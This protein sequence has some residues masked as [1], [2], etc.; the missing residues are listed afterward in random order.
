MRRPSFLTYKTLR[1][2]H[3]L[4]LPISFWAGDICFGNI[5]ERIK[6]FRNILKWQ[7]QQIWGGCSRRIGFYDF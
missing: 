7:P 2:M 6:I 4:F 3:T 5:L 1:G